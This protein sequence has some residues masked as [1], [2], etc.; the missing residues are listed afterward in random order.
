MTGNEIKNEILK[1]GLKSQAVYPVEPEAMIVCINRAA[2]EVN[3]LCPVLGTATILHY[4]ARPLVYRHGVTVHRGGEELTIDASGIRSLAFAVSGTGEGILTCEG[5]EVVHSF[6]WEDAT[7]MRVFSM[8]VEELFGIEEGEIHLTFLG[9]YSY[10]IK[11][12]SLYGE[13]TGDLVEDVVPYAPAVRYDLS[14]K[15][16]VG[17]RFQDFASLPVRYNDVDLNAPTDYKIEGKA[18]YLPAE[19]RGVYEVS[20]YKKPTPVDEDNMDLP[21]EIDDRLEDLLPL[22]AAYYFYMVTD[23][24]VAERCNAEYLRL[25]SIVMATMRKIRTPVKFRDRRGW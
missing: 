4:P 19:K 8:I 13:L 16:H 22:R 20:Y 1:L 10:M 21:I 2:S 11:D 25:Q 7:E 17:E 3:R 5:S 24:E 23:R 9:K 14:D 18:I 15:K 6:T 12:L